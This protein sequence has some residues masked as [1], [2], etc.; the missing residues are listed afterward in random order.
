M[1]QLIERP[2]LQESAS[3]AVQS[4]IDDAGSKKDRA[5]AIVEA[6][7]KAAVHDALATTAGS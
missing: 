1:A 6:V 5:E 2:E 4:L 3:S 7:A